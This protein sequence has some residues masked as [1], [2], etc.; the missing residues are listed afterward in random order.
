[1]RVRILKMRTMKHS[2]KVVAT[3][4][5]RDYLNLDLNP[6]LVEFDVLDFSASLS[7]LFELPL[8]VYMIQAK[9]FFWKFIASFFS[10]CSIAFIQ[11][12]HQDM[13]DLALLGHWNNE[14]LA[15]PLWIMN[16]TLIGFEILSY[17]NYSV[18]DSSLLKFKPS[19]HQTHNKSHKKDHYVMDNELFNGNRLYLKIINNSLLIS[20]YNHIDDLAFF[21]RIASTIIPE[22][23][24]N[25]PN[26][27]ME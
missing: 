13:V 19:F 21:E 1:M 16:D 14:Q 8:P 15:I 24:K 20:D 7:S 23:D 11:R 17:R 22:L 26:D 10:T 4:S 9:E 6:W 5:I 3:R 25:L 2:S 12:I 18:I 27:S